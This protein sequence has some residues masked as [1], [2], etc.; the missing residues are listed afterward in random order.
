[1]SQ[2]QLQEARE[3]VLSAF[4]DSEELSARIA[5]LTAALAAEKVAFPHDLFRV[6]SHWLHSLVSCEQDAHR[7]TQ[8]EREFL[9]KRLSKMERACDTNVK[10]LERITVRL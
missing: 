9:R 1:V 2:A 5:E 7:V 4:S 8:S 10:D 3:S 6:R